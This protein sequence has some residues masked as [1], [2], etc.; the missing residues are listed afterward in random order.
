MKRIRII[1]EAEV[2]EGVAPQQWRDANFISMK[3][4]DENNNLIE[5]EHDDSDN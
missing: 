4:F 1:I 2:E 5:E 3:V